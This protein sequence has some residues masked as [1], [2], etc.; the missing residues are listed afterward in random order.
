MIGALVLNEL[1]KGLYAKVLVYQLKMNKMQTLTS[2]RIIMA[3]AT[4]LTHFRKAWPLLA[5]WQTGLYL[6]LRKKSR[7]QSRLLDVE[8]LLNY[9]LKIFF[10][11]A[12]KSSV[13][14]QGIAV[15]LD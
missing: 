3:M 2:A 10:K 11:E 7:S 1:G 4:F 8:S 15:I 6:C 9:S 14:Q 13:C 12:N 5:A